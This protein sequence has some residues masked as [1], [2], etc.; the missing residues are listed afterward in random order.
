MFLLVM[1]LG[2]LMMFLMIGDVAVVIGD[3][4]TRWNGF[5]CFVIDYGPMLGQAA[6]QLWTYSAPFL[7]L[8]L[9]VWS[10]VWRPRP[11][12]E[13]DGRNR[14]ERRADCR[15]N[16]RYNRPCHKYTSI[17]DYNFHHSY[18]H[19]LCERNVFYKRVPQVTERFDQDMNHQLHT[20]SLRVLDSV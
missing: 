6:S 4:T 7:W 18:P 9:F 12:P 1:F 11:D 3:I 13:P 20:A 2:G 8:L 17:K 14:R 15:F 16:R 10:I 5:V 19:H